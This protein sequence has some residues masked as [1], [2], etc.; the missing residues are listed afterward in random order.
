M[1]NLQ[2]FVFSLAVA[3]ASSVALAQE[4]FPDEPWAE[5]MLIGT[6]HYN[7]PGQDEFNVEADDVLASDRQREI[8]AISARLGEWAPD[9]IL[10]E[11]PWDRQEA[12]DERYAAWLADDHRDDDCDDDCQGN[13][14]GNGDPN[15]DWR[16][17]VYQLGARTAAA[18]GPER[19]YAVDV[20]YSMAS[21]E[22]SEVVENPDERLQRLGA[23]LQAYGEAQIR[24]SQARLEKHTLGAVLYAKNT[25]SELAANSDFYHR[26]LM[27]G[28]K[29]DNQGG[30][31]SVAK[32]YTRNLLIYQNIL[33]VV[34]ETLAQGAAPGRP[35]K[36]MV[37]YGQGHIPTLAD[38]VEDSPYLVAADTA[39]FLSVFEGETREHQAEQRP[40]Q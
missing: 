27:R 2:L 25:E 8:E 5:V 33:R 30:A 34:E 40:E 22:Y 16:S 4:T 10:V 17:E 6:H 20:E 23:Q 38:F 39:E 31:H 21:D 32:W 11:F 29:G 14:H 3:V 12:L 36:F 35:L 28:W 26:F 15:R 18:L 37:I 7:N 19:L 1:K 9:M 13:G 24:A